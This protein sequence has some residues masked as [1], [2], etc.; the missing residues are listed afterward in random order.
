M[1]K[2]NHEG[3]SLIT[4]TR[5][6]DAHTRVAEIVRSLHSFQNY[7]RTVIFLLTPAPTATLTGLLSLW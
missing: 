5:T 6:P 3:K 1:S 2:I 7:Y 4:E